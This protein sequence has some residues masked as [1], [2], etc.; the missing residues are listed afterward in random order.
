MRAGIYKIENLANGKI[1]IGQ[2]LDVRRRIT[3]HRSKLRGDSHGNPHLQAAWN[4]YGEEQFV[5]EQLCSVLGATVE[6]RV[7]NLN[8]LEVELIREYR[9]FVDGYNLDTGGDN[10]TVS[11]ATRQR[12]RDSHKGQKQPPCTPEKRERLRIAGASRVHSAATRAKIGNAGRGRPAWNKGRGGYRASP[13]SEERKRKI[14]E[15]QRGDKNH[16]FGKTIPAEVIAKIRAA[17]CGSQCYL[18]KL[19][20]DKVRDIKRR[21]RLG[22]RPSV[23]A[24]EHNVARTQISSIRHGKTWRHVTE[25]ELEKELVEQT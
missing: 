16:N 14:S 12:L 9:A 1:Y 2:S 19:N 13:A 25:N 24:R 15:A 23:L 3:V 18:A 5:F 7:E 6:E 10:K 22:E 21:L 11:E 17:N 20:E 8:R 4:K